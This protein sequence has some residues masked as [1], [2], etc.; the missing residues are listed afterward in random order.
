M[1]HQKASRI[2][3]KEICYRYIVWNNVRKF[4][5]NRTNSFWTTRLSMV[6]EMAGMLY[7][8]K[9]FLSRANISLSIH[10]NEKKSQEQTPSKIKFH[11]IL[12]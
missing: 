4:Q 2:K 3:K 5:E 10:K 8:S 9:H 1:D 6:M 7:L 12:N 11:I